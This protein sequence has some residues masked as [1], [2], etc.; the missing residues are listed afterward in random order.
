[1]VPGGLMKV[2]IRPRGGDAMPSDGDQLCYW[3]DLLSMMMMMI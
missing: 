1:M 3:W 2:V